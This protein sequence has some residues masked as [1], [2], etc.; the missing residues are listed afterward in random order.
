MSDR[1]PR[2]SWARVELWRWQYG[3]LPTAEDMRPLS[4]SAGLRGMAEA[5]R[6]RDM[7]NFPSPFGVGEV[8]DY[9][10]KVIEEQSKSLPASGIDA[11]GGV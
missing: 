6:K 2:D 8:L 9:A 1:D 5:I 7:S 4:V 10:A 3:C 11:V